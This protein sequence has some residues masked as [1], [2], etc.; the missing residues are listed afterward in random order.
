MGPQIRCFKCRGDVAMIATREGAK[1]SY[2]LSCFLDFCHRT[3]RDTLFRQCL[4]PPKVP[5]VVTVSGGVNSMAMM[6]LL[7]VLKQ[8]NIRRQGGGRIVFDLRV[9]HLTE[10]G[11]FDAPEEADERSP[12]SSAP[13][14]AQRTAELVRAAATAM[15]E[16][17]P[18]Y[19]SSD[20]Y[21]GS[22]KEILREMA[23][24]GKHDHRGDEDPNTISL[25]LAAL[26]KKAAPSDVEEAYLLLKR[27]AIAYACRTKFAPFGESENSSLSSET[28]TL[29]LTGENAV[30]CCVRA[31]G[32]LT[33]GR[34]A[35]IPDSSS[36]RGLL[37]QAVY[38]MRPMRG[39]LPKEVIL[40]CKANG[41]PYTTPLHPTAASAA[42]NR[43]VN[44][45]LQRFVSSLMQSYPSTPFNIL[46]S[47][48]KLAAVVQPSGAASSDMHN[49]A[50]ETSSVASSSASSQQKFILTKASAA[51]A[52]TVRRIWVNDRRA[53]LSMPHCAA[54]GVAMPDLNREAELHKVLRERQEAIEQHPAAPLYCYGCVAL[55]S[56]LNT[57][58]CDVVPLV[59][60]A[61]TSSAD[62]AV[63][64]WRKLSDSEIAADIGEYLI[65][66]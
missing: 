31:L 55:H 24:A 38:A 19:N 64:A 17:A 8:Q 56:D 39:L 16:G 51:N 42:A 65:D 29:S 61:L 43:S 34:G 9:L 54:C 14:A 3:V 50:A 30:M 48:T 1:K 13:S 66:V 33:R 58:S 62:D 5:V 36:C 10:E 27:A 6:H 4:L 18:M 15:Y 60:A 63:A 46:N 53:L 57:A 59:F 45:I 40:Y 25:A 28:P 37:H 47:V 49:D 21:I 32:D 22:M 26:S 35:M 41:V 7:G 52:A 12:L 11:L 44:R 2:C 23:T 20:V